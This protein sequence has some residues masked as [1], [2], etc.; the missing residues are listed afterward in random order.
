[1]EDSVKLQE[2]KNL[3]LLYNLVN[4]TTSATRVTKKSSTLIDATVINK[5]A[6]EW[7][8]TVL[9]LGYSYHLAQIININ[10]N[11]SQRGTIKSRK[12]QFT[13]ES[14]DEFNYLLQKESFRCKYQ[15]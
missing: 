7:S 2:L 4:T 1:M 3:L 12:R 8:S 14:S 10:L 6:Y 13:K 11:R 15:F 5:Q 9:D